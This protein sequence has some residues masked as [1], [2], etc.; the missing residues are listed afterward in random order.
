MKLAILCMAGILAA[1][2]SLQMGKVTL[3][4]HLNINHDGARQDV[5][6]AFYF[7]CLGLA[8]D[9]RKKENLEKKIG[10]VWANGGS[11]QFHFSKGER[12]QVFD[13]LIEMAYKDP[14]SLE[15]VEQVLLNPPS[16]LKENGS[17]FSFEKGEDGRITVT[18]FHGTTYSLCVDGDAED[19]RGSQPGER[20]P[21]TPCA[22][23]KS[24]NVNVS[25]EASLD[26]IGR[27]YSEVFGAAV[28]EQTPSSVAIRMSPKQLLRFQHSTAPVPYSCP[29]DDVRDCEDGI[30]NYGAHISLYL[31]DFRG[32]YARS[33]ALGVGFVNHRFKRRA[34][35]L[36]EA[37]DQCMFRTLDIVDPAHP[38]RGVI[39]KLEH[40]V[41]S[42]TQANGEVY[43]SFP[44]K[45][46]PTE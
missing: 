26:G 24:L 1:V 44:L 7:D 9:P 42:M 6:T 28:V 22:A 13:G 45:T 31:N 35:C 16:I 2:D 15:A 33:Q 20:Q 17:K 21:H 43:K 41:R 3:M 14:S 46:I 37:I 18:D 5:L 32:A 11:T 39:L 29:H 12:A 40:E 4:D 25:P 30:A 27:F 19:M 10:T 8:A 23:I 34:Y 36:E 38:D